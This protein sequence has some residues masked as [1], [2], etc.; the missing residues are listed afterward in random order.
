MRNTP[1]GTQIR[2]P[3]GLL[4]W[5]WIS[6][7]VTAFADNIVSSLLMSAMCAVD[8]S[9]RVGTTQVRATWGTDN[10]PVTSPSI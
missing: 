9:R 3:Q 7:G 6:L 2:M 10:V 1:R 5:G 8:L 4:F